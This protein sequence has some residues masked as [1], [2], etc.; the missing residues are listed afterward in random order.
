[1][2]FIEFMNFQVLLYTTSPT[3]VALLKTV[4][5]MVC[6][7]VAN[8]QD[9]TASPSVGN[10][11]R[12][13]S[14]YRLSCVSVSNTTRSAVLRVKPANGTAFHSAGTVEIHQ[15]A[16][17]QSGALHRGMVLATRRYE[18]GEAGPFDFTIPLAF[19]TGSK[20]YYAV[21][22]SP[23]LGTLDTNQ[24]DGPIAI[25]QT[26]AASPPVV[27][28]VRAS[29]QP[30]NQLVEI[31]YDLADGNTA[32]VNVS[33]EVS[34]DGGASYG[35]AAASVSGDIGLVAP[36][37]GKKIIWNA[38]KDWSDQVSNQMRFKVTACE[39]VA[40]TVG[41]R[42]FGNITITN[43][44][45]SNTVVI[46]DA[47]GQPLP[48]GMQ[49]RVGAFSKERG[50]ILSAVETRSLQDL[51][52]SFHEVASLS[53]GFNQ[54]PGLYLADVSGWLPS[55]LEG[56][57][58]HVVISDHGNNMGNASELLIFEHSATFQL[59]PAFTLPDALSFENGVLI[60]G[61]WNGA[62]SVTTG[63]FTTTNTA[64]MISVSP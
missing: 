7:S 19:S 38:G 53:I 25:T 63:N 21:R 1:M 24:W 18:A 16:T 17:D 3:L 62:G 12:R 2:R 22:R 42:F 11:V 35:V 46:T 27:S 48:G 49:V 20:L 61:T 60:T 30:G 45:G 14:G 5:I 47:A 13:G 55:N 8:G 23:S 41:H 39:T 54:L 44:S 9:F 36:G 57:P 50:E 64:N 43:V 40:P 15:D 31:L 26:A 6:V 59:A 4:M 37:S 29:Q 32:V 58:V 28:R 52:N 34:S 56:A 33:L 51:E 10:E